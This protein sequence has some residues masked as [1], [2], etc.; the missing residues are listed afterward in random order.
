MH[1]RDDDAPQPSSSMGIRSR[2]VP[3]DPAG[4]GTREAISI[5][6]VGSGTGTQHACMARRARRHYEARHPDGLIQHRAG[7]GAHSLAAAA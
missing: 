2:R 6:P 7:R 5:V 3:I 4:D 1:V